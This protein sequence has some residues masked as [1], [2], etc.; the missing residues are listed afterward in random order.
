M[1]SVAQNDLLTWIA[2][3]E[4][5]KVVDVLSAALP[6]FE[7]GRDWPAAMSNSVWT[8]P[9]WLV[10]VVGKSLRLG[11]LDVLEHVHGKGYDMRNYYN[12][13]M[14]QFALHSAAA[15]GQDAVVNWLL[16][17]GA[18]ARVTGGAGNNPL[19][20]ACASNLEATENPLGMPNVVRLLLSAGVDVNERRPDG[21]TPLLLACSGPRCAGVVRALLDGG[22][23]PNLGMQSY[24]YKSPLIFVVDRARETAVDVP[25][26][27]R[28]LE[29]AQDDFDAMLQ[30]GAD[31]CEMH[32]ECPMDVLSQ[33]ILSGDHV[34]DLVKRVLDCGWRGKP[35]RTSPLLVAAQWNAQEIAVEL[36]Q[37]GFYREGERVALSGNALD[38][39]D[40]FEVAL[41]MDRPRILEALMLHGVDLEAGM[42]SGLSRREAVEAKGGR[43]LDF[44]K[45]LDF[46]RRLTES[47]SDGASGAPAAPR[48]SRGFSL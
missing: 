34:L 45:S 15:A 9:Q 29:V 22:A 30:S 48:R 16:D 27:R 17:L 18:D 43:C 1:D 26:M 38:G 8:W 24:P 32:D 20:L 3:G 31:P 19:H 37:R 41:M 33:L 4:Q 7:G 10:P 13:R 12:S 36:V 28:R 21:M 47:L 35:G 5:G 14:E 25:S 39:A 11:C 23:D 40:I 2:Q 42:L 6:R 46:S 44:M